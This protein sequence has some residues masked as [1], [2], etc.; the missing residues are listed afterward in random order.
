MDLGKAPFHLQVGRALGT[1]GEADKGGVWVRVGIQSTSSPV[2]RRSD[3][4]IHHA[5]DLMRT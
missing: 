4:F 3:L 2:T 1:A 5:E